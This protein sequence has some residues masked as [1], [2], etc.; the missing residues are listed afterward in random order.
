[1]H[2]HYVGLDL[3]VDSPEDGDAPD[4]VS[5]RRSPGVVVVAGHSLNRC[6]HQEQSY[7]G[8]SHH[9]YA[10]SVSARRIRTSAPAVLAAHNLSQ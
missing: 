3:S 2:I 7:D 8:N 4:V 9:P 1:M 10:G 6:R 5:P